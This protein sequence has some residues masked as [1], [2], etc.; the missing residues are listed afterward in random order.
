MSS[1]RWLGIKIAYFFCVLSLFG[2]LLHYEEL[3]Y[4]MKNYITYHAG[5]YGVRST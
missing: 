3:N 2:M 4:S 1:V 5:A